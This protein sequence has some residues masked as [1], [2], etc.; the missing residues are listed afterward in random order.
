MRIS[1]WSSDVCSSD[2]PSNLLR[3]EHAKARQRDLAGVHDEHVAGALG[4]VRDDHQVA[5]IRGI[6]R[7]RSKNLVLIADNLAGICAAREARKEL[8][9]GRASGGERECQYV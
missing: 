7:C 2:L 9:I 6:D 8:Q 5:E 4:A 1:D 3:L